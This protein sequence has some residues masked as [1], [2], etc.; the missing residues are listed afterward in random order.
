MARDYTKYTINNGKALSKRAFALQLVKEFAKT[1]NPT[2][3]LLKSAF[4]DSLQGSKGFLFKTSD[5]Y[6]TKRFHPDVLVS[7]DG[8]SF[9]VSNQWGSKNFPGLIEKAI[10]LSI[11]VNKFNPNHLKAKSANKVSEEGFKEKVDLK[12]NKQVEVIEKSFSKEDNIKKENEDFIRKF[13]QY[14]RPKNFSELSVD[15]VTTLTIDAA[16]FSITDL[17]SYVARNNK[18][19]LDVFKSVYI[20]DTI[21]QYNNTW[22]SMGKLSRNK[23]TNNLAPDIAIEALDHRLKA[24]F[25]RDSAKDFLKEFKKLRKKQNK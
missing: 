4:P 6:D 12:K 15:D 21:R 8:T 24:E 19:E 14:I 13:W 18:I 22:K 3:D 20:D 7:S 25:L 1:N 16:F 5:S 2:Y 11:E 9:V 23:K 17:P 10:E